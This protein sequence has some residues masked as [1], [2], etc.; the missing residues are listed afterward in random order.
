MPKT[1]TSGRSQLS[2]TAHSNRVRFGN[3]EAGMWRTGC[4]SPADLPTLQPSKCLTRG[5]CIVDVS[6]RSVRMDGINTTFR[7]KADALAFLAQLTPA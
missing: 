4:M 1:T 5:W 7:R 2:A 3:V 6:G